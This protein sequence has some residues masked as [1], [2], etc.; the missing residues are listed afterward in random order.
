M[1]VAIVIVAER[2]H[3]EKGLMYRYLSCT[4]GWEDAVLSVRSEDKARHHILYTH[5]EGYLSYAGSE[6]KVG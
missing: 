4:C 6:V 5:G 1:E 2:P 3:L